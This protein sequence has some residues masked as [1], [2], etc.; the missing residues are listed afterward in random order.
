MVVEVCVTSH[1]YDRSKLRAYAEAGVKE[2]WLVLVPEKRIEVFRQPLK[3]QFTERSIHGP[4]GVL[5]S[6]SV[7]RL[8]IDLTTL[9]G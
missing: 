5:A 6:G 9:F 8:N 2:C 1:E 7:Q 3:G 4:G